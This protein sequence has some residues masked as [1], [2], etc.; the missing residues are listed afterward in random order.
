MNFLCRFF[1]GY[2]FPP[3][4]RNRNEPGLGGANAARAGKSAQPDSVNASRSFR[5]GREGR[6]ARAGRWG[7]RRESP[8]L[9][10]VRVT[11]RSDGDRA[12]L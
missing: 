6:R 8:D 5:R 11:E 10:L 2:T 9:L 12:A 7:R 1:I 4:L 3:P